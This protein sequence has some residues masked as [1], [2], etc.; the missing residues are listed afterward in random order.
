MF[1]RKDKVYLDE[2]SIGF[3]KLQQIYF[4]YITISSHFED[5]FTTV[6]DLHFKKE[7]KKVW[8]RKI[9]VSRE[10]IMLYMHINAHIVGGRHTF[11]LLNTLLIVICEKKSYSKVGN[12]LES[13][14]IAIASKSMT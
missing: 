5:I 7:L 3:H 1:I 4:I 12:V 9:P 11:Y 14:S 10:P 6:W 2:L 8:R 13:S